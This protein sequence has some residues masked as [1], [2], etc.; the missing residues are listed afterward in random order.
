MSAADTAPV[1]DQTRESARLLKRVPG[2]ARPQKEALREF[3]EGVAQL[4]QHY[5]PVFWPLFVPEEHVSLARRVGV[6]M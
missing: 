4:R 6:R 5:D 1:D 2:R 3:E